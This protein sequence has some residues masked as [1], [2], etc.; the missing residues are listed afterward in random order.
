M[1]PGAT[2]AVALVSGFSLPLPVMP[3]RVA[4]TARIGYLGFNQ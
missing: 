1:T 3:E 2:L 4:K